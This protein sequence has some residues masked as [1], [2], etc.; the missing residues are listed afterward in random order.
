M[1]RLLRTPDSPATRAGQSCG[2][3]ESPPAVHGGRHPQGRRGD[4]RLRR[5]DTDH[6]S[7]LWWTRGDRRRR[8]RSDPRQGRDGLRLDE[9]AEQVTPAAI[10]QIST[11]QGSRIPTSSFAPAARC[12][13]PAFCYGKAPIANSTSRTS[14]GRSSAKSTSCARS[15]RSSRGRDALDSEAGNSRDRLGSPTGFQGRF[16]RAPSHVRHPG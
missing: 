3:P 15:A 2:P 8:S 1:E 13:Y 7:C 16:S 6:R 9:L 5:D 14:I 4:G 11:R 10:D 12:A